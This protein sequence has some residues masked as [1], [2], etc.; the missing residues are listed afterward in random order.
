MFEVF[1]M[2]TRMQHILALSAL[3][4][5]GCG[6]DSDQQSAERAPSGADSNT[7]A[8]AASADAS[9][10]IGM[11]LPDGFTASLFA[12]GL[13]TPRHI[14][15]TEQ[16][17]VYVTLRSGQAKFRAT[18]EAGGIAALEDTDGD[19]VADITRTFGRPG[20][21]T[22]LALRD[23]Y[24]YY[25]TMT[26]IYAFPLGSEL[27]P[28]GPEEVVIGEM[29]RSDGGHRTKAITFDDA[30]HLYTQVGSP[31][32]ACQAQSGTPGSP[33]LM[34]C[35]QLDEHGGV[36]RFSA[37]SRN[38][39]HSEDGI[40]YST[41]HRNVVAL[42]WNRSAGALYLMMHGRD[43]LSGLWPESYSDE[44]DIELPAEEFHRIAQGDNLG[45][46]YTYFDPIRR[47]RMLMPEYGGNGVTSAESGQYKDPL[48]GFPGHWAP[49]D[50]V[51]YAHTQFPAR[52]R[53]GAFLAFHGP[54]NPRR[55]DPGGYSVIF[56]P[57]NPAGEI[58]GDWEFF[59]DDFE[60]HANRSGVAG[61]PAGLAIGPDGALF[62]VD[63]A[64][65]RI[66][67]VTYTGA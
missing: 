60:D 34:P 30:G 22:G 24:L 54:V 3:I 7:S 67:K 41:G 32:N 33:G 51:F 46:P 16:G 2:Q 39:I 15:V 31:S 48:I 23:G 12:D 63:D 59:A 18:D 28:N 52:Y 10:S 64:G 49:N 38:Q 25:S 66:W 43:G 29:P 20:A 55:A 26:G 19:G 62:I 11:A 1:A 6:A 37:M 36:F 47:Q 35:T 17:R 8:N 57:M 65:G 40:R 56:V 45:W 44:Q 27:L 13:P 5:T 53:D 58:T 14:A 61:R 50:I 9:L 4:M 21:D 42:E